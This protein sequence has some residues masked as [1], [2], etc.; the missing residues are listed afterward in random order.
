M[1]EAFLTPPGAD[2]TK[3]TV[4]L[5][6]PT[7]TAACAASARARPTWMILPVTGRRRRAPT[8]KPWAAAPTFLQIADNAEPSLSSAATASL[9]RSAA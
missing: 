1:P 8:S 3:G 2:T 4:A 5:M 7:E 9:P 6:A